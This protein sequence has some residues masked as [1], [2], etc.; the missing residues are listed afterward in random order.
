[1]PTKDSIRVGT[2]HRT[3]I[4]HRILDIV[5]GKIAGTAPVSRT[6][7]TS[8]L[9][10][11]DMCA[12]DGQA[13]AESGQSSP[14]LIDKHINHGKL[15]VRSQACLYE[16]QA[17]TFELL[18]EGYG[19]KT[20]IELRNEDS[21]GIVFADFLD[22]PD[23]PLFIYAD[24]NSLSQLPLT[25]QM[26]EA[27]LPKFTTVVI[28]MGCNVGGLKRLP[29][30]DREDWWRLKVFADKKPRYHDAQVYWVKGDASQWAYLTIVPKKFSVSIRDSVM[31]KCG[32]S[33][34]CALVEHDNRTDWDEVFDRL[35]LTR[36]ERNEA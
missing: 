7:C 27:Q 23:D 11:V 1:M 21:S 2:S 12:G 20:R 22:S 30:E 13:S 26:I 32:D 24:P 36:E 18:R 35:F 10:V 14:A 16:K 31:R 29:K 34:G 19:G 9:K 25:Q 4:K 3:P 17:K 5:L 28:T 6:P 8:N 15:D 33:L